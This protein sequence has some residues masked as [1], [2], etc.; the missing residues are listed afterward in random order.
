MDADL[1]VVVSEAG[2]PGAIDAEA[3][4]ACM[5]LQAKGPVCNQPER[6]ASAHRRIGQQPAG[7]AEVA[8][9]DTVSSRVH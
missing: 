5:P 6:Q 1:I 3:P 2:E 8:A 7:I 4:A 9:H